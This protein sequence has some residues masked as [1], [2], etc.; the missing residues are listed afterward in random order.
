MLIKTV[1]IADIQSALGTM[2]A[3]WPDIQDRTALVIEHGEKPPE[4]ESNCPW[5]GVYCI[6]HKLV[7]RTIGAGAG[8]RYQ[9]A[10]FWLVVKEVSPNSGNECSAKLESLIQNLTSA[11]LSDTSLGGTV[12]FMDDITVNY[13]E[14]GKTTGVYLQTAVIQFTVQ[15]TVQA[16]G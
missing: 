8:M 14:W 6:S 1:N 3:Q 10:T 5:V 13:P 12:D 4:S 9:R 16:G 7:G 2:L 15:T 11:L